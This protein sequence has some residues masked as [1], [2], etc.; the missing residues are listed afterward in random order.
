MKETWLP[1][2]GLQYDGLE[3]HV[4]ASVIIVVMEWDT[5]LCVQVR[6]YIGSES[7]PSAMGGNTSGYL[8]SVCMAS[9]PIPTSNL[10]ATMRES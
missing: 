8:C 9:C 6:A 5:F 3:S 2:A 4:R 7:A 1:L 10:L